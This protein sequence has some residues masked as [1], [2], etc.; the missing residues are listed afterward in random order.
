MMLDELPPKGKKQ[1]SGAQNEEHIALAELLRRN[2]GGWVPFVQQYETSSAASNTQ[3]RINKGVL[4]AFRPA[5]SFK[6]V[7]RQGIL[8]VKYVGEAAE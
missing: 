4:A 7:V 2:P 1:Q 5:G 8:Y 3:S 6:A